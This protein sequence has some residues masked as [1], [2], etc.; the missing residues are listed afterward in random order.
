VG[1]PEGA[2]LEDAR[3]LFCPQPTAV[4]RVFDD[5]PF[6]V[7]RCQGC[8]LVFVSPRVA[9]D[10][11][12]RIYGADYWRSPAAKDYGYTDYRADA[13][14]W[15][16]TYRRRA[17]VLDGRVAPGGRIL[18]IGCAAGFFLEVMREKGFD[19]W[20]LEVS[21]P[22]AS[23]ARRRLGEDRIAVGTLTDHP[24]PPGE[25]DLVSFWDVVEH[26]PDPVDALTRARQLL[27][28]GGL[29]LVET[30]NIE[31]R[32]AK[33]MGRRWQHFKQTEHLYHFSPSTVTR[34]LE[35]SG[36]RVEYLTARWAGKYVGLDF[37][38]ERAGKVHP[39]LS[40]ALAPISRF[41]RVAPYINLF[42]EMI[43]M[44]RPA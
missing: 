44:A 36:F 5:P 39:S 42:D 3:C 14:H 6:S 41:R 22:I 20:G 7:V 9:A 26:L 21:A 38:A 15:L 25:F 37:I 19:G 16:R 8:S 27:R 10:Q 31:S 13:P 11:V 35:A 34:L 17:Q 43:V 4:D 23:E 30:Q 24:Y 32:F 40:R 2:G 18:D 1:L 28:P 33:V 12:A 29:L